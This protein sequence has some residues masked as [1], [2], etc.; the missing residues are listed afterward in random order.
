MFFEYF[1]AFQLA[2]CCGGTAVSLCCTSCPSCR[3]STST[4]IMYAVMLLVGAILA[5]ITL[6]PG[7]QD[8]LKNVP[9]CKN[10]TATSSAI[11]P[12]SYSADCSVAVG[13]L[14]VYRICFAFACFFALMA[15]MMIGAKSSKDGR[16]PIQNGFWGIKYL[17]VIA[18][19]VGAFFIPNGSFGTVWMWIGLIGG[20][21]FIL[22]Q[23]VL[24]VDFAHSW[25]ETWVGEYKQQSRFDFFFVHFLKSI[26]CFK[27]S[28]LRRNWIT[29]MVLR[30]V[31]CHW[32]SICASDC[33]RRIAIYLLWL[34]LEQIL[35]FDQFDSVHC[36][37]RVV[38]YATSPRTYLTIW[39]IAKFS[40]YIVRCLLDMVSIG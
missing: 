23:L 28:K 22:V 31:V 34:R 19:G 15:V 9:F 8:W 33:R 25:A 30:F 36:G 39:F 40:R 3:N 20:V 24:I 35:Y 5:G 26:L 7:L 12:D 37:K 11:I 1:F 14:A 29:W 6:A 18:I 32:Y 10:S 16:A 27:F 17:I 38:D 21:A 2:C 13:Y 4:R